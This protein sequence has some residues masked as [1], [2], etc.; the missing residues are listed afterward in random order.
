[1]WGKHLHIM[2]D[3]KISYHQ[4]SQTDYLYVK[5][6][7]DYF[8]LNST[9][10]F[11]TNKISIEELKEIIPL[12]HPV[13]Q[14]YIIKLGNK[15]CGYCYIGQYKKREAYNRTA[16]LTIY[17]EPVFQGRGIGRNTIEF[18][19]AKAVSVGLKNLVA[20]VT[21]DN[22]KSLQLFSSMGFD[23]VAHFKNIG[24]KFGEI[25]DVIVFQK[26]I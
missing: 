8:I 17:I 24:E 14:G 5:E 3:F 16:E 18:L 25:L 4:V 22:T 10:T 9:A 21:G 13:Y 19:I 26:E 12:N 11:H 20:F 2:N 1:M 15:K 23:K 6:V 7:Y